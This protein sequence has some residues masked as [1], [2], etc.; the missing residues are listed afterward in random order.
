M[1]VSIKYTSLS[2]LVAALAFGLGGCAELEEEPVDN[3]SDT[4]GESAEGE[5]GTSESAIRSYT[6]Y[7]S[8][9]EVREMYRGLRNINNVCGWLPL[10]Y[11]A[12]LGCRAPQD[13]EDAINRAYYTGKRVKAVYTPCNYS[14]CGSYKY[15]V[16]T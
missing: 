9:T 13:L 14:Y 4:G 8:R 1:K 10:P 11:F 7:Y 6:I 16:V 3:G 15:Y 2:L 5:V 12:Q